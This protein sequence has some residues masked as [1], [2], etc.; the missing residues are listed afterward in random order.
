MAES[1]E[2]VIF[3]LSV[4]SS[5]GNGHATTYRAL[6]R[7][8]AARGHRVVFLERDLPWY[9]ENRDLPRLPYGCVHTYSSISSAKRQFRKLVTDADLVIVGSYV[10]EGVEIGEWVTQTAKGVKAF[11]DIDTPITLAALERRTCDYISAGLMSAFDLYLS[12][13]G[14]PMLRRIERRF[15]A[16]RAEPLYCSVDPQVHS[17]ERRATKW[18][19]GYIGTY[20]P[21]RQKPLEELML[22]PAREWK[23]S[24]MVVAG[25]QYPENVC[26]PPNVER[27]EHL[28]PDAHRRFYNAQRYT[29]NLTREKM[30]RA[31]YS[32]SVRLFEAAACGTPIIS[33]NWPGLETFFRPTDEILVARSGRDVL[34]FLRDI[35][36]KERLV[37][38]ASARK[39]ILHHHTADHRAREL[40]SYVAE[41]RGEHIDASTI[42][43]GS[44]IGAA[45]VTS[46]AGQPG[47]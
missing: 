9:A 8:L 1:L 10:P 45:A 7:G 42:R 3:G 27:V 13:T 28:P 14:G 18:D 22:A 40:E 16:K 30:R 24:R 35:P 25:A 6:M 26:W 5:W 47:D 36:E 29:L 38:G 21:D 41:L 43:S 31:G 2:V 23:Q 15:G 33:D 17:P 11:Y 37:I 32:P 46:A 19:L 39:K 12:F 44:A 20:S 4:T 34:E